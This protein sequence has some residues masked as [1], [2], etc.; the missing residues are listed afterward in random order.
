MELFASQNDESDQ[1]TKSVI[2][3]SLI[4]SKEG[5]IVGF[6]TLATLHSE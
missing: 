2:V 1:G 6:G 3:P 5:Q 4:Y